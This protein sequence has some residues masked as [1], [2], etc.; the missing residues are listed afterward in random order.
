MMSALL[1]TADSA[2]AGDALAIVIRSGSMPACSDREHVSGAGRPTD[3]IGDKH[4]MRRD[5]GAGAA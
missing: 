5:A 3:L 1:M 2:A 4:A